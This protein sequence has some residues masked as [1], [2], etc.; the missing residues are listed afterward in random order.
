MIASREWVEKLTTV[1]VISH[2]V[3]SFDYGTLEIIML[4]LFL[5]FH[6]NPPKATPIS[7]SV[8]EAW[9][10]AVLSRTYLAEHP[11]SW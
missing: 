8:G 7:D 10:A 3:I 11:Y 9:K 6:S 1:K 4:L 2:G 5:F